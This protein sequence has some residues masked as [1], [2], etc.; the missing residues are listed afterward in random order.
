MKVINIMK[1][2]IITFIII[3]FAS[4]IGSSIYKQL[5]KDKTPKQAKDLSVKKNIQHLKAHMI[6]TNYR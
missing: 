2:Y 1:K 5:T 3:F 6:M 4:A